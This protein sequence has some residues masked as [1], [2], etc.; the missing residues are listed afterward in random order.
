MPLGVAFCDSE[1]EAVVHSTAAFDVVLLKE[2][3]T[4]GQTILATHSK[5]KTPQRKRG[6]NCP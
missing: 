4:K 3:L 5:P 1:L 6:P 2:G